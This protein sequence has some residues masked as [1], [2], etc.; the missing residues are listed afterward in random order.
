MATQRTITHAEYIELTDLY[1]QAIGALVAAIGDEDTAGSAAYCAAGARSVVVAWEDPNEAQMTAD[2]IDAAIDV[3]TQIQRLAN[4]QA[5][6]SSFNAAIIRHLGTTV[7]FNDWL[8]EGDQRVH[9]YYRQGGYAGLRNTNVFPPE[10][11]LGSFVVTGSG[12]GTFTAGDTVD[13][14]Y[15]G[16]AQVALVTSVAIGGVD[17][18]VTLTCTDEDGEAQE[19]TGIIPSG[20]QS[21]A[22]IELGTSADRIVAVTACSITGGTADDAF[23]IVTLEDRELGA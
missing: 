21:G 7:D 5:M 15:Y 22:V 8:A 16:G 6:F 3:V 4:F 13:T 1:A 17:I 23:D 14:G 2:F 11:E 10:T 12:Q 9:Y 20:S 19:V 18:H